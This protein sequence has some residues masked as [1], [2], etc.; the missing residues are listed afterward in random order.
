MNIKKANRN[1]PCPC[2]SGK[3]FKQCCQLLDVKQ[4]AE[5]AIKSRAIDAIPERFKT[6]L[7]HHQIGELTQAESIYQ[8]ILQLSPKHLDALHNLG[9]LASETGK[10]Q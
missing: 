2:G 7:Q 9:L 1:D 4:S 6:A 8:E 10:Q 5:L 3:K